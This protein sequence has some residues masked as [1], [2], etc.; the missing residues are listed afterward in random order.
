MH[1]QMELD[2]VEQSDG[3]QTTLY[4]L[5]LPMNHNNGAP[6][7]PARLRWAQ[8]EVVQFAGG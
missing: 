7:Q 2:W 8:Q 4:T 3:S 6:M 1:V 5:F